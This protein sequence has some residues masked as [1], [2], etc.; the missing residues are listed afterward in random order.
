[1]V[2]VW[3]DFK[4]IMFYNSFIVGNISSLN[5][6]INQNNFYVNEGFYDSNRFSPQICFI[7]DTTFFVIWYGEGPFAQSTNI[8]QNVFCFR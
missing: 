5:A 7:S 6:E 8:W 1:M 4:Y 3:R 2:T